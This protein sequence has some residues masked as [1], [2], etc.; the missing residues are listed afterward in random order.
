MLGIFILAVLSAFYGKPFAWIPYLIGFVP[1]RITGG[2]FHAKT[3]FACIVSFSLVFLILLTLSDKICPIPYIHFFIT[4]VSLG[5]VYFLAPVEAVNK[6]LSFEI[7]Q[8]N[9]KR[10]IGISW[11]NVMVSLAVLVAGID[12]EAHLT[13]YFAGV[14][15]AGVSMVAVFR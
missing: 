4:C 14:F 11:F 15:S 10:C 8:K 6:H 7:R 5:I 1:L 9:R 2:G 12:N 3:H 13:M